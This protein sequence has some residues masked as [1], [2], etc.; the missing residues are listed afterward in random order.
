MSSWS[1]TLSKP[2][3]ANTL[4]A[5]VF[6]FALAYS[7]LSCY[8]KY[9][10]TPK[11][12]GVWCLWTQYSVDTGLYKFNDDGPDSVKYTII[13]TIFD[14]LMQILQLILLIVSTISLVRFIRET[15]KI[16][17]LKNKND[18]QKER[19]E[20]LILFT[21]VSFFIATFPTILVNMT[22]AIVAS[23][24]MTP[25]ILMASERISLM[26]QTLNSSTH[27]IICLL[28]SSQYR[29]VV[30]NTFNSGSDSTISVL[31]VENVSVVRVERRARE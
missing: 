11:I 31:P 17:M 2:S 14:G 8:T 7:S 30:K 27:G 5:S 6:V 13:F 15:S 4:A 26:M 9:T 18:R 20:G 21:L 12:P 24:D 1:E 25:M 3:F 22:F 29:D 28:M 10:I 23:L 16:K 19:T